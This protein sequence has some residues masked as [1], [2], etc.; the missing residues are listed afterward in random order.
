M[1]VTWYPYVAGDP[2]MESPS[3]RYWVFLEGTVQIATREY[4]GSLT[5]IWRTDQ[6]VDDLVTHYATMLWPDPPEVEA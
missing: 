2:V 6:G 5:W 3:G 1:K 4:N